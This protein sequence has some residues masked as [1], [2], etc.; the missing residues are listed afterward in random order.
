MPSAASAPSAR[1]VGQPVDRGWVYAQPSCCLQCF[2]HACCCGVVGSSC[3]SGFWIFTPPCACLP[4][5]LLQYNPSEGLADQSSIT[6]FNCVKCA[7]GSMPLLNSPAAA[8]DALVEEGS[9]FCDACPAGTFL[10][11]QTQACVTCGDDT[12]R[13]GDATPENNVC[14]RIPAGY[15]EKTVDDVAGTLPRSEIVLCDK[16]TYSS[17]NAAGDVRTPVGSPTTCDACTGNLYAP[18]TGVPRPAALRLRSA[19]CLVAR[20]AL[21]GY[22]LGVPLRA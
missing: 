9:T 4:S 16:G 6:G 7:E 22:H 10:P 19:C 1:C 3:A 18:R 8:V 14:K 5:F 2:F 15:R 13:T 17:W 20:V 21:R 11:D 12:Y